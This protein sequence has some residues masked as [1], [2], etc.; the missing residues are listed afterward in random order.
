MNGPKKATN[1]NVILNCLSGYHVNNSP[2][3]LRA[4][5]YGNDNL[6]IDESKILISENIRFMRDCKKGLIKKLFA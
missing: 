4:L 3:T 6:E 1:N 2:F 5:L